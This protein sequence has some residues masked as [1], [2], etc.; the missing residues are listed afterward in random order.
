MGDVLHAAQTAESNN[1]AYDV[2]AD[3]W[4]AAHT[5][6]TNSIV[7]NNFTATTNPTVNDDTGDG[8]EVGSRWINTNT[9]TLFTCLD[10]SSGAAI[11]LEHGAGGLTQ[12]YV[13][14]NTVGAS[15]ETA[16][17]NE[18]AIAK[19]IILANDCLITDVETYIQ[20]ASAGY[21][22]GPVAA[23]YT[24]V[25]GS[26]DQPFRTQPSAVSNSNIVGLPAT[27]PMWI[28]VGGLGWVVAGTYWLV[29]RL[30]DGG[31]TV[32]PQVA[33]DSGADET[34]D[35]AAARF[36]IWGGSAGSRKY[37]IRANTVR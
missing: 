31:G 13:G 6:P 5:V 33:Y 2:S 3:A 21:I 15:W 34:Q 27:T 17:V 4:E 35:F 29:V 25:S 11:W 24:D 8:Y 19:Q 18:W 26:P 23:L 37:S 20:V 12:A 1:P 10:A 7:K 14:Y 22:G 9:D 36:Q 30:A 32:L 16:T 28:G